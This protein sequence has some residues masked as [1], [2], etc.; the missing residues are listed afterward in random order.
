MP[1]F[2]D[3]GLR[4]LD[5]P[6]RFEA[7]PSSVHVYNALCA[8][9][10]LRDDG[11][12]FWADSSS[13]NT[14]WKEYCVVLYTFINGLDERRHIEQQNLE[15]AL[16]EFI[17]EFEHSI[18]GMYEMLYGTSSDPDDSTHIQQIT[19]W[20]E[21]VYRLST[22]ALASYWIDDKSKEYIGKI[23]VDMRAGEISERW[24]RKEM[25]LPRKYR[26]TTKKLL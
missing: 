19:D 17:Q 20:F 6:D 3:R 23:S 11:D 21:L 18:S 13:Q 10:R 26:H 16:R 5:I 24:T 15:T 14:R 9:G 22:Y 1:R 7:Q 4:L 25:Q 8:I 12:S 2:R